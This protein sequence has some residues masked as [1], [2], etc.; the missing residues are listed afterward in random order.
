LKKSIAELEEIK[1][2]QRKERSS[3]E[4]MT[5]SPFDLFPNEIVVRIFHILT[6]RQ[7]IVD[8]FSF[9]TRPQDLCNA[10]EVCLLWNYLANEDSLYESLVHLFR[11]PMYEVH[12]FLLTLQTCSK[13]TIRK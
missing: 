9:L 6:D 8:I 7:Q 5:D 13:Q 12:T 11:F 2:A 10:S 1:M 4:A 3:V